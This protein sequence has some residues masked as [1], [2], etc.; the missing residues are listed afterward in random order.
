M[1]EFI[2][3]VIAYWP[4]IIGTIGIIFVITIGQYAYKVGGIPALVVAVSAVAG[5][6]G[7]VMGKRGVPVP[8][9]PQAP[10]ERPKRRRPTI[11]N[12]G[13]FQ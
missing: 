10:P 8:G 7:Y 11:F 3:I 12:G 6:V 5:A 2:Q 13:L 4:Y 9:I 1:W